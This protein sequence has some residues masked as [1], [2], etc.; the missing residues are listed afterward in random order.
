MFLAESAALFSLKMEMT[1][2]THPHLNIL[3]GGLISLSPLSRAVTHA[4]LVIKCFLIGSI[5][6][7]TRLAAPKVLAYGSKSLICILLLVI[8][9]FIYSR[10]T[11]WTAPMVQAQAFQVTQWVKNPST[12]DTEDLGSISWLGRSPGG[13]HGNPLQYSCLENRQTAESGRYS[14]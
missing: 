14:P 9:S 8:W 4:P 12:W 2:V 11:Y 1:F 13:G 5:R 7:T 10:N 6:P 3:S